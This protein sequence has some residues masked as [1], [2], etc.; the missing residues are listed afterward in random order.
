MTTKNRSVDSAPPAEWID[1]LD[2]HDEELT[3]VQLLWRRG[4]GRYRPLVESAADLDSLERAP[5]SDWEAIELPETHFQWTTVADEDLDTRRDRIHDA[6]RG[7]WEQV[8]RWVRRLGSRCDFKLTGFGQDNAI[9]FESTRRVAHDGPERT[10]GHEGMSDGSGRTGAGLDEGWDRLDRTK[11]DLIKWLVEER[12]T[13][14]GMAQKASSAAPEMIASTRAILERAIDYQAEQVRGLIDQ[15]T[16]RTEFQARAYAER[17][18][19]QRRA[20]TMEFLRLTLEATMT[21]V[22]PTAKSMFDTWANRSMQVFPEFQTAQQ[23]VAYLGLTL[24][25]TQL[26]GMFNQS[27]VA[28]D[29]FVQLLD[30]VA[31]EENE[32]NA[33]E[34]MM[35]GIKALKSER[36]TRQATLEQQLAA[37]YIIGRLAMYRMVEYGEA[38]L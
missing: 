17:Q 31:N 29:G 6:A 14:F 33:L 38:V 3:R 27:Q 23:A 11:D 19:T 28:A 16:G 13:S 8:R 18:Q 9:L 24:T 5:L 25:Q 4:S 35:V 7:L 20:M 34:T 1:H 32:R 10:S 12:N 22:V 15:S 26:L 37:R 2:L 36:F 21:T 30:I